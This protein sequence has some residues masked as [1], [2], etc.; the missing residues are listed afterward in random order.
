[1]KAAFYPESG[2]F[3]FIKFVLLKTNQ[4]YL[5]NEFVQKNIFKGKKGNARQG[6]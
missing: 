4:S 1:M 6:A 3:I 5:N 2:F